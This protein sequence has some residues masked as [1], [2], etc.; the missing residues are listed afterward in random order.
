MKL[1]KFLKAVLVVI[2]MKTRHRGTVPLLIGTCPSSHIEP[3][4]TEQGFHCLAHANTS[5]ITTTSVPCP[6]TA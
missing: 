5:L 2:L 3:A 6:R 4:L 1:Q